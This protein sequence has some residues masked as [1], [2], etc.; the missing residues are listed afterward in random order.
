M[1][2]F[3]LSL[4]YVDKEELPDLK[5]GLKRVLRLWIPFAVVLFYTLLWFHPISQRNIVPLWAENWNSVSFSISSFLTLYHGTNG[6]T[7]T[8]FPDLFWSLFLPIMLIVI[9]KSQWLFALLVGLLWWSSSISLALPF[10]F[11]VFLAHNQQ[12]VKYTPKWI[13]RLGLYSYIIFVFVFQ[14]DFHILSLMLV[15]SLLCLPE[16]GVW[17][18][19]GKLSLPIYICHGPLIPLIGAWIVNI[20]CL[21]QMYNV[22]LVFWLIIVI[23]VAILFYPVEW[24]AINVMKIDYLKLFNK[25]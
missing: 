6:A 24:F 17:K 2:G 1:S 19:S 12:F 22:M 16:L 25:K 7:W 21:H 5:F 20:N 9:R 18:H 13:A 15:A 3:V 4:K 23:I 8:L 10:C 11:G 14:L